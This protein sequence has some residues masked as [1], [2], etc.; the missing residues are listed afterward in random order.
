MEL[1]FQILPIA[2]S[3][4]LG[5]GF[6]EQ[7]MKNSSS[8]SGVWMKGALV[9]VA[10]AT[11]GFFTS[12][13]PSCEESDPVSG[14]CLSYADDGRQW[15][16]EKAATD[17]WN[18]FWKTVAGGT[19]GMVLLRNELESKGV[20]PFLTYHHLARA[21]ELI[22][23]PEALRQF[24]IAMV[25]A[26][27]SGLNHS[28]QEFGED[29][30]ACNLIAKE[31][32]RQARLIDD[33]SRHQEIMGY[34]YEASGVVHGFKEVLPSIIISGTVFDGLRAP[35]NSAETIPAQSANESTLN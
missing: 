16:S 35:A 4:L 24:L 25:N 18:I 21:Q 10:L 34:F 6:A 27:A 14:G 3:A 12:G 8:W 33:A 15:T 11:F 17:A 20:T 1:F 26:I 2:F 13:Q 28:S 23:N 31:V 29:F 22:Q 30:I 5:R 7:F 32:L 19:I 9:S